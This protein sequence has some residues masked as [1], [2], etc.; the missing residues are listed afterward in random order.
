MGSII[1]STGKRPGFQT[2]GSPTP[3]P[4]SHARAKRPGTRGIS[5]FVVYPEDPGFSIAERIEVIAP[6]P[7]ATIRF[8]GCRIPVSR[9]LGASGEGFKIAMRTL[10]IFRASVAAAALAGFAYWAVHGS[11]DWFFE[12]AGLGAPA[13]AL[14]GLGCALAPVTGLVPAT[15]GGEVDVDS[16]HVDVPQMED[17]NA[18]EPRVGGVSRSGTSR[19]RVG[20]PFRI[21]L[22]LVLLGLLG[23]LAAASLT[24]PWLSE[25]QVQSAAAIWPKAPLVAYSRLEDAARLNPLSDRAYL[26][27]GSIA[28]RFGDLA[29]A[30][31][32]FSLA[33]GRVPDDA[34]AAL[35]LGA[36]A[37]ESDAPTRALVLLKRAVRLNPRDPLTRQAL[38]TVQAGHEVDVKALNRAILLKAEDL[39]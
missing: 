26:V 15:G 32:A 4:S 22:A 2:A 5:A 20:H 36:I 24:A 8:E 3:I 35:E 18:R 16:S 14:L 34:Y 17:S 25:R 12:F 19:V 1:F 23:L 33:L 30:R 37:S 9:R 38:H 6:H 11:F 39:A 21:T 29:R 10:D 27:E 7:L 28:L 13:F 31:R